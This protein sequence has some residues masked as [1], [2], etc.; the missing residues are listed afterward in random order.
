[1]QIC[2]EEKRRGPLPSGE[3]WTGWRSADLWELIQ[4]FAG[5][6]FNKS[7]STAYALIAYMTAY[8]KAHYPV[9]F[10]AALLTSEMHS[11]DGVVKFI[12]ECRSH[13]IEV[14]PPDINS[15]GLE[16]SVHDGKIRFGMVAVKNVGESALASIV[17][18]REEND[19]Y[20][21]LIDFCNRVDSRRVNNRVIESL[22]KSGSF[23][24]ISP[25]R[26]QLAAVQGLARPLLASE[27]GA[28]ETTRPSGGG[29][30]GSR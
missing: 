9:E 10:M 6:G 21:S 7:H 29:E 3:A 25:N 11:I 8:L 13:A 18:E 5:Y 4:K 16:F 30:A 26:A 22:I 2:G 20:T 27:H 14:L 24:S 12:A 19:H 15:S 28:G 17:E 23:D 1:M